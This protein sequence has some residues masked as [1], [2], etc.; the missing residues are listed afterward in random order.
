MLLDDSI[1]ISTMDF[2]LMDFRLPET[3]KAFLVPRK[4]VW[5]KE[6]MHEMEV[7]GKIRRNL[8]LKRICKIT[9]D[10]EGTIS[11]KKYWRKSNCFSLF[12]EPS[13][14]NCGNS[15]IQ[16]IMKPWNIQPLATVQE[17]VI[18]GQFL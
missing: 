16:P 5:N 10:L 7:Y 17:P 6:L 3:P 9:L 8:V 4:F 12:I 1:Q 11:K 2:A 18:D 14:Y 13:S 15:E